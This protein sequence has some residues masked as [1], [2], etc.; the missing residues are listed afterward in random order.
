M[1]IPSAD[2]NIKHL[3]CIILLRSKKNDKGSV[4]LLDGDEISLISGDLDMK[5]RAPGFSA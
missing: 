5:I 2:N 1:K 4:H 3:F